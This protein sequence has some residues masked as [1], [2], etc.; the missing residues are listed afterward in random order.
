MAI[1]Q[2]E[3]Y[4]STSYAIPVAYGR[5]VT[6]TN[7]KAITFFASDT[8]TI[9]K[10]ALRLSKVL[11]NSTDK[12]HVGIKAVDGNH[13]PTG[14]FLTSVADKLINSLPGYNSLADHEGCQWRVFEFSTPAELT[15]GTE[16]AIIAYLDGSVYNSVVWSGAS[17][18]ETGLFCYS[19]DSGSTWNNTTAIDLCYQTYSA[20]A[21]QDNFETGSEAEFSGG[22]DYWQ[23]Q[24][25]TATSTYIAKSISMR[26][27]REDSP[28]GTFIVS[29]RATAAGVPSGGD[30]TVGVL[31][32]SDVQDGSKSWYEFEL[33]IPYKIVS[34]TEYAIIVRTSGSTY[35]GFTIGGISG[36]DPYDGG[37][38][39]Y[40][41][42]AGSTWESIVG[43]ND[44]LWFRVYGTATGAGTSPDSDA[45]T[46]KR[47]WSISSNQFWYENEDGDMIVLD[48]ATDDLD[49]T[50]PLTTAEAYG[51]IFIA[52]CVNLKV[53]DF[54]N[55]KIATADIG[56][57]P[58]D[59]GTVLTGGD[60][61]AVM[62]VDYIT[63]I[64]SAVSIYGRR[65]TEYAFQ[66]EET[67]TGTDD[68]GNSISFTTSADETLPPHW[69]DWTVFGNDATTFGTMP[70]NANLVAEYHGRLVLA[71]NS[72][73]PHEWW[74]SRV[75][76]PWDFQT[77]TS[78][79]SNTYGMAVTSGSTD[80]GQI[81]DVITALISYGDDFFVFGCSSSIC[82]LDGDPTYG[83]TIETLSK[84]AGIYGARAW[85]KDHQSN[86][87]F[88]SGD[89]LY[90]AQ[91]GRSKPVS[92][93]ELKLPKWSEDW[94][95]N[96]SLYRIVVTFDPIRNGIIVSQTALS[97][98]ANNNY[99]YDLKTE[100]FYPENYPD[101]CGVY[102]SFYYNSIDSSTRVLLFGCNDGYLR[103]FYDNNKNDIL[104]DDS[105]SAISSWLVIPVLPL[106]DSVDREGKL[107][108]VTFDVGGGASSGA[109]Q[110]S[111]GFTYELFVGNDAETVLEDIKDG[112]TAF[113]SGTLSATG[114]SNKIRPRARG[115]FVSTRLYNT[116]AS[117]T[118]AI[119]RIVG[120][121]R[122]LKG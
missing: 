96:P 54:A 105:T 65:T 17:S 53:A 38:Q 33:D 77:S 118:W 83:G 85:C 19:T 111:D 14:G 116:T 46:V 3:F 66:S 95:A 122:P 93:S 87:Y 121:V 108:S 24:V 21:L 81:G 76:N 26:L 101:T 67:V 12:I 25:F 80:A 1:L 22:G 98:G 43:E 90:K 39:L 13:E 34:G 48:D 68:D 15:S 62:V 114:R 119:N 71:G 110:D 72:N 106:N 57:H 47:L 102:S 4:P 35:P 56:S 64:A 117:E 88:Y 44:D 6:T 31:Y 23:G 5:Y 107:I 10:V 74:M 59:F 92:L 8:Y 9:T 94:E 115:Y 82:L 113:A 27:E 75:Y 20:Y 30:L 32:Q 60:S 36:G 11:Y 84:T 18:G 37:T 63:A 70:A 29:I 109:F 52:N 7:W 79:V 58:P 97:N 91:G 28:V 69:Y 78:S 99:W 40:S 100:G 42:D 103:T 50:R 112:A 73:Y 89:G 120:L 2:D 55:V 16:Y 45:V 86:L 104:A 41:T 51:K 61:G 49:T